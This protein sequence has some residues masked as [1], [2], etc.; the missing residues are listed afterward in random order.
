LKNVTKKEKE[1]PIG[2]ILKNKIKKIYQF[3][4]LAKVNPTKNNK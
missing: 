4:K 3:I 2:T 1:F